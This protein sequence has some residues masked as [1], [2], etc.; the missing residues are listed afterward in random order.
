[1]AILGTSPPYNIAM[2]IT[3]EQ[4]DTYQRDGV[5]VLRGA[6]TD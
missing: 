4:I 2:N 5:L 6:F 3:Q 1:M